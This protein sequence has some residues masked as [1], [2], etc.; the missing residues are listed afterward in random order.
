MKPKIPILF[1]DE[2]LVVADK[3]SGLNTIPDRYQT[4]IPDL[5]NVLKQT[6][7]NLWV[8]HRI[9][10][11]TSGI[12]LFARDED[13]H[14]S[15]NRQFENRE[16]EKTYLALCIGTPFH[17][18]WTIDR[19]LRVDADRLHRTIIDAYRGKEA[20]TQ[21]NVLQEFN[22]F[23]WIEAHPLTG[24][25]HQVRVHLAGAGLPIVADPL[26]GDGAHFLLSSV[27]RRYKSAQHAEEKP[28]LARLA[29]HAARL[30]FIHPINQEKMAI[31]SPVPKDLQATLAQL[32]KHACR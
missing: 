5:R 13:V 20:V 11:E 23:C 27:K 24:R 10:K 9:D 1:E 4:G 30:E 7:C 15:L 14:K 8:I 28:L 31:E 25:T 6:F 19:P 32:N 16:V 2:F 21:V 3:P 12:V 22:G 18:S 26:Y 17:R 29:L